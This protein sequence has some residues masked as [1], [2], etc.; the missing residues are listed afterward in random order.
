[1]RVIFLIFFLHLF[2]KAKSQDIHFSQYNKSSFF[3]NPSI[4]SFQKKQFKFTAIR[5]QQWESITTPFK[6]SSFSLERKDIVKNISAGV[7]YLYD[8]AGDSKFKTTGVSFSFA[9]LFEINNR[10]NLSLAAST[11]FFERTINLDELIFNIPENQQNLSVFFPDLNFGI[12]NKFFVNKNLYLING[13]SIFHLNKPNQSLVDNKTTKLSRKLHIHSDIKYFINQDLALQPM[14]FYSQ[15]ET[16]KESV[17]SLQLEYFLNRENHI[18]L[19]SMLAYRYKDAVLCG[20]GIKINN[21]ECHYTYDIN[22]SS[23]SRASNGFGG[24]EVAIVYNWN[25]KIKQKNKIKKETQWED[26]PKYL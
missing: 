23:L 15:K 20:F 6:T 1:M 16:T 4:L 22:T 19:S 24:P 9:Y 17:F 8:I 14:F 25:M 11:G 3:I 10:N 13:L 7:N 26:C 2:I 18:Y 12:T 21:F 5:R